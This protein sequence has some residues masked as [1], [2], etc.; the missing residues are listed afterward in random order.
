M[1]F[2]TPEGQKVGECFEARAAA[3]ASCTHKQR[4]ADLAAKRQIRPCMCCRAEFQS[5][6]IHNRLCGRCRAAGDMLG[7]PQR[8]FISKK[9]A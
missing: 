4:A 3:T 5:E 1:R 9:G 7:D 6:G 8:P 2:T